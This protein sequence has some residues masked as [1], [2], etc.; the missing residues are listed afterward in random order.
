M[1]AGG[2]IGLPRIGIE[3]VGANWDNHEIQ[4]NIAFPDGR[5]YRLRGAGPSLS[6]LGPEGEPTVLGAGG[7]VFRC[8]TP[9]DTWTMTYDGQA[10]QTSSADLVAGRPPGPLVDVSITVEA[11]MVVP[12]WIQG[13]LQ[14]DA[15]DLFGT[16]DEEGEFELPCAATGRGALPLGRR[17]DLR[18]AGTLEPTRQDRNI[19]PP[20]R[21]Q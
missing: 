3:A 6:P 5:V 10:A 9:F 12:P 4:I 16:R 14:A 7:L 19:A 17:R 1:S 15:S 8:L 11:N 2:R 21:R 20:G 13:A 18:N